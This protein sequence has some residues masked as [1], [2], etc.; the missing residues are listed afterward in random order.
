MWHKAEVGAYI[1]A[2][3]YIYTYIYIRV[4]SIN[5]IGPVGWVLANDPPERFSVPGRVIP[6]IQ[7]VVLDTSLFSPYHYKVRIK[8]KVERSMGRSSALPYTFMY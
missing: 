2:C 4:L 6:K 5:L 8:S 3:I 1:Y 7:K